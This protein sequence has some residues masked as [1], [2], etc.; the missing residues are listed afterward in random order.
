MKLRTN[1]YKLK[2]NLA[3]NLREYNRSSLQN[4]INYISE[5]NLLLEL[6]GIK[7]DLLTIAYRKFEC[8]PNR[9]L[10]IVKSG[11]NINYNGAC[12]TFLDVQVGKNEMYNISQLDK[13]IKNFINKQSLNDIFMLNDEYQWIISKGNDGLC[14]FGYLDENNV[15]RCAIDTICMTQ[16]LPVSKY[17]PNKCF[18]WPISI[19]KMTKGYFLT[20]RCPENAVALGYDELAVDFRCLAK[21]LATDSPVYVSLKQAIIFMFGEELYKELNSKIK[22]LEQ[23]FHNVS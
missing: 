2:S 4:Y 17:K 23:R 14:V 15:L 20:L 22:S 1:Q 8:N 7:I 10:Q 5:N 9:C 19:H 18:I 11:K 21:P 16:K 3:K 12:C 13:L 6:E